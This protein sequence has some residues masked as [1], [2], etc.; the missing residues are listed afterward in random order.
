MWSQ[1][2]HLSERR[3]K[4]KTQ[5]GKGYTLVQRVTLPPNIFKVLGLIPSSGYWLFLHS[6]SS[7][8]EL[9]RVLGF[10]SLT[11]INYAKHFLSMNMYDEGVSLP[12]AQ[13]YMDQWRVHHDTDQAE[14]V[15][16]MNEWSSQKMVISTSRAF[17]HFLNKICESI[18]ISCIVT[19]SNRNIENM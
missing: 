13:C 10:L 11:F 16:K 17:P 18:T 4:L 14:V 19:Y 9:F 12:P 3:F 5:W 8:V 1:R 15:V 7:L 6:L 2:A